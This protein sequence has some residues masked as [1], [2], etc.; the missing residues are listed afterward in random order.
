MLLVDES[1]MPKQGLHSAA[2]AHQYCGAL[3]KVTSCQMGVFVGY[4]ST[5]GYT[6]VDG[7][8][9]VPE[10]SFAASHQTLRAEVGMPADLTFQTKPQL[11]VQLLEAISERGVL[12]ARWVAADALYGDSPAF[13]DAVAQMGYW[14]FTEVA[15]SQLIW[16]RHPA[17]IIPPWSGKGR[18]PKRKQLKTRS[19]QPYRVDELLWRLPKQTWVRGTV[20]EGS[21]GPIV[22]D[23]AFVRVTEARAALPGP[24]LWLVMRRNVD[25]PSVVKYYLC[26]A[27]E[28]IDTLR[29]VRMSGM[30][31]PIEL[32]FEV[33]KDDLGMD[34]YETRSWLGWHHHMTLIMLAHQFLVWVRVQWQELAPA[35][36]LAQVQLLVTSVI[37]KPVL[38]AARALL[39]VLYYRRRNHVAY[40][41]HR[42]RKLAQ[43][44][45]L[46]SAL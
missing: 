17:V 27:P 7:R 42:K 35:L 46:N 39:L 11:A 32:T 6:L 40:L 23:F 30:R 16:R 13:R 45:M 8:L 12:K 2:V 33:G 24:R 18:K 9:F 34:Q 3:G 14:Y 37:L 4:A 28:A 22:C 1:G 26:N 38:D 15:C 31:W 43:L 21:K 25:D 10:C 29:L 36:T 19:N 41:S 5:K 44:G 20:K